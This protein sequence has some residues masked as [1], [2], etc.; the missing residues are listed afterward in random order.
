M[1]TCKIYSLH[2]L[3]LVCGVAFYHYENLYI[4][5]MVLEVKENARKGKLVV[6]HED[7]RENQLARE[8]NYKLEI[9]ARCKGEL[10]WPRCYSVEFT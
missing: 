4:Q 3:E 2:S 6:I 1:K 5:H 8:G 9:E 10:A 7:S